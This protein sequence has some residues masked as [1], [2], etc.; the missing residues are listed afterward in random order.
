M[1]KTMH[2][3]EKYIQHNL[4]EIVLAMSMQVMGSYASHGKDL[5]CR[6]KFSIILEKS[7]RQYLQL[8]KQQAALFPSMPDWPFDTYLYCPL[9]LCGAAS[10]YAQAK[11]GFWRPP[12][13]LDGIDR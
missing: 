8:K 7:K 11:G 12:H 1:A 2:V 5:A 10:S 6:Q 9:C 13:K 3:G 4:S